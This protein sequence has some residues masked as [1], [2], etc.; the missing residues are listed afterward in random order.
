MTRRQRVFGVT[1]CIACRKSFA[2]GEPV[3]EIVTQEQPWR[4][5]SSGQPYRGQ[6]VDV[7]VKWHTRCLDEEERRIEAYRQRVADEN[8]RL[9]A[10]LQG[11]SA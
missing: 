8:A 2:P 6:W 5:S 10:E 7:T 11:A 9:I 1:K 3:S 4:I